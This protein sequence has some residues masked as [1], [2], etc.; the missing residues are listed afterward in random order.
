[1]DA[2]ARC[3]FLFFFFLRLTW[4]VPR[5]VL[6][7][8]RYPPKPAFSCERGR[9][10][11]GD[12][13]PKP[14][15]TFPPRPC[16]GRPAPPARGGQ[17]GAPAPRAARPGAAQSTALPARARPEPPPPCFPYLRW[18]AP[19]AP[20]R[21]GPSRHGVWLRDGQC[22]D[23]AQTRPTAR[24]ALPPARLAAARATVDA[25]QTP[26]PTTSLPPAA[27]RPGARRARDAAARAR[28]RS[29]RRARGARMLARAPSP[30]A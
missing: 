13:H 23:H 28:A 1:M 16:T 21:A 8:L 3:P 2:L 14:P 26:Q 10:A 25:A 12:Q 19:P 22:P 17:S 18:P 9:W 29:G 27:R 7:W 4:T 11:C 20:A 30:R 6:C 24:P 15:A 5:N